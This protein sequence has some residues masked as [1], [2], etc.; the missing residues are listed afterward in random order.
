MR[1]LSVHVPLKA[2]DIFDDQAV[3]M[4]ILDVLLENGADANVA[5]NTGHTPLFFALRYGNRRVADGIIQFIPASDLDT[6]LVGCASMNRLDL[7]ERPVMPLEIRRDALCEKLKEDVV[8]AQMARIG[9]MNL[10]PIQKTELEMFGY[11]EDVIRQKI[12]E[13]I[14]AK[15]RTHRMPKIQAGVEV[16]K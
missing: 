12:R 5:N 13:A 15:M 7:E 6:L 4:P 10:R 3:C 11:P 14:D 2:E 9:Y 1:A 8:N 16:K